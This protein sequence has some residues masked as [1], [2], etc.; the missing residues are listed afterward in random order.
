MKLGARFVVPT[1]LLALFLAR[2]ASTYTIF[3]ETSDEDHHIYW[4]MDWFERGEYLG[5]DGFQPPLARAAVAFLPYRCGFRAENSWLV[6][7]WENQ[8]LDDFWTSLTLARIGNLFFATASFFA[9]YLWSRRLFG[10]RSAW[11]A[12]G[13]L[14][15]SPTIIGH[16]G[17]AT[18]DLAGAASVCWALFALWYWRL[19]PSW[20][21]SLLLGAAIGVAQLCKVSAAGFLALPLAAIFASWWREGTDRRRWRQLAFQ[22]LCLTAAAGLV[23]WAVYGFDTGEIHSYR[24]DRAVNN[25]SP[26][27]IG[28]LLQG[29][30]V[31]APVFWAGFVDMAYLQVDGHP[32][33]LFGEKRY[34]G[35]WYYFPVALVLKSTPSLLILAFL[36]GWLLWRQRGLILSNDAFWLPGIG[37]AGVLL[38]SIAS[39]MNLGVRFIL[40]VYP[41][42]AVLDSAAFSVKLTTPAR[43]RA[44]RALPMVLLTW[45]TI[46]SALS[47][48]DYLA[49][50]TPPARSQDYLLLG[51][52]NL[53]WGQ[54][55][56]RLAAFLDES[57]VE[58]VL[59]MVSGSVL[60]KV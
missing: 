40:P 17:L 50:F 14:V 56:A 3:S 54:D 48:P 6:H 31:P 42:L 13:L 26:L 10:E 11:A 49:Y 9:V 33:F 46:E 39:T 44:L 15:C 37:V 47:H 58:D 23:V 8:T 19:R 2:I 5:G 28:E 7:E 16:A 4:G 1:L 20:Q 24:H 18:V 22:V 55:K 60:N 25:G 59:V 57:Q 52:S 45:H 35:W 32:A 29:V 53:D 41:L 43:S 36:G 30:R 51:D 21:R 38:P 34:H 27:S 12:G